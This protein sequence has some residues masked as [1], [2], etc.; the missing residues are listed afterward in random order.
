[1]R[2]AAEL[3]VV[4]SGV[5]W[6]LCAS[7]WYAVP[8]SHKCLQHARSL[9]RSRSGYSSTRPSRPSPVKRLPYHKICRGVCLVVGFEVRRVESGRD[10]S[11]TVLLHLDSTHHG[12]TVL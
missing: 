5:L 2:C 10:K 11:L 4:L 8:D 9:Q 12:S 1:M 6:E 3:Y 7:M